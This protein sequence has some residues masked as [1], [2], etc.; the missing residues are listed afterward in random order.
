VTTLAWLFILAGILTARQVS[1]G[2]VM[3]ISQDLGDA[4]I[5]VASG[6][7]DALGEVLTRRGED[8][9]PTAA[10]LAVYKLTQGVTEGL[11][12]ATVSIGDGIGDAFT[13]LADGVNN[14]AIVAVTLGSKA[15]GYRWAATGPDYYDCS[16]LMWRACQGIGFTGVRFTTSTIGASSQFKRISPPG[17]Q[18]PGVTA[19]TINDIVVWPTHHMGVITG[20]DKFYSARSVKSGIGESKISSFRNSTPVY[21]RY[22]GPRKSVNPFAKK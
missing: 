13:Q 2:R 14:L 10:D 4:F 22:V 5:A 18:G 8:S 16:G 15:K 20:P 6:D 11:T 19:A 3:N 17:M 9:A 21:Y 7:T 1:R 12:T